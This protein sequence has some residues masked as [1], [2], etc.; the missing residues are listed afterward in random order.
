MTA[1]VAAILQLFSKV[2][3]YLND[4]KDVSK[5]RAKCAVEAAN[6]NSLLTALRFRLEEGDSNTIWYTEVQT[7]AI[8]QGPHDQFKQALEQLQEKTSGNGKMGKAGNASVWTF[9]KEEIDSIL[10]RMERLKSLVEIALQMDH[11]SVPC[12]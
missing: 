1:S 9:K 8:E 12:Q 6:L 5:D 3:G 11:L 7:L 2:L 4:V 10:H